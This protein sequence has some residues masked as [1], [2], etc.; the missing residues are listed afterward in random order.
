MLDSDSGLAFLIHPESPLITNEDEPYGI[1]PSISEFNVTMN[2]VI[3]S[4]LE[5]NALLDGNYQ[6]NRYDDLD[7]TLFNNTIVNKISS[8]FVLTPIDLNNQ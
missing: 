3:Y 2:A 1:L 6:G 5:N 7:H 8:V 4:A